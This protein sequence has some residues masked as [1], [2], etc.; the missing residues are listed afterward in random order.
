MWEIGGS[1][2]MG[3][4]F[5]LVALSCL[6]ESGAAVHE[7]NLPGSIPCSIKIVGVS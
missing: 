3:V 2:G 1:C 5:I 4:I 6:S 7:V